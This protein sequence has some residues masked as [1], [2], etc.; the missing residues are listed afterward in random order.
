MGFFF[1]LFCVCVCVCRDGMHLTKE[2]SDILVKKILEIVKEADW[3][4]SLN[5][6]KI[7]DEFSDIGPVMSLDL[8]K[9]HK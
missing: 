9:E 7:P 1:L 5:W 2:G 3:E 8:L 4:P 6:E